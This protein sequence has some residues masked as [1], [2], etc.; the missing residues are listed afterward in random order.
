VFL[1]KIREG[2]VGNFL[3]ALAGIARNSPNRFKCLVIELNA[4]PGH[5]NHP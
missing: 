5:D 1:Q 4:L 3:E 2:F